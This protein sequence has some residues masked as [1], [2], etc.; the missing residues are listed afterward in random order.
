MLTD[1]VLS[2]LLA[3]TLPTRILC[4]TFTKAAAAE[5]ANR[6]ADRL[7]T[8][9]TVP[10]PA[11]AKMLGD[12]TGKAAARDQL[13]RA[14]RLFAQVVDAPGGLKIMTIH[15]F[16]QSLLRRFPLEAGLSPHFDVMDERS[17]AEVMEWARDEVLVRARHDVD[18]TL[19]RALAEVTGHA[20]EDAFLELMGD[21][22][23][24]RGRLA[25]ALK[26]LGGI[27]R[28]VQAVYHRLGLAPDATPKLVVEEACAEDAFEGA[29]LRASLEAL[30]QGSK[31]DKERGARIAAWLE[32][33][34]GRVRR[35]DD[36][37]SV[38]ITTE[39]TIRKNLATKAVRETSPHAEEVLRRE[40]E[41]IL[42]AIDRRKAATTAT[43]TIALLRLGAA[44]LDSY[45]RQKELAA[46]LDYDDLILR[47]R[48]LL[49]AHG[50]DWVLY[51]LDQGLDHILI[52]EAQ[53]TNPD[54]WAVIEALAEEFFVGE[55]A[56][57]ETRTVFAVG[58]AKQ[59][60][61]SF[62]RADPTAFERMRAHFAA[63]VRTAHGSWRSVAL[64]V[65][66]RSAP[67]V[68][69]AVDAV[70]ANSSASDGVVAEGSKMRHLAFRGG[71]AGL[72]ELWPVVSPRERKDFEPWSP[73]V[74]RESADSPSARLA[75]FL[76]R[77]IGRWIDDG[78]MLESKARPIRA[79]DVM[80]L[81]RR[82]GLFVDELVR[83]L[84]E[85]SVPVAGVDRMVLTDQLA[86]MDVMAMARFLLLPEDDLSLACVLKSPLVGLDED[87]LFALAYNRAPRTLWQSLGDRVE[88]DS[89]F[90]SAHAYLAGLLR[91][92]DFIPPYE[93]FAE[94]LGTRGR[95]DAKSGRERILARLGPEAEEP[96]DEFLAQALLYER[97]R[98]PS[99]EGFLHWIEAGQGEIKRDPE[100]SARNEV[101]IMTVHGAKGLQAPIVILPDTVQVPTQSPRL[102]WDEDGEDVFLWPPKRTHEESVAVRLRNTA[103][104]KRDQE[105]RRLLYV[106]MT[107]A[108][109]RLYVCG[110]RGSREAAAGAWHNLVAAGLEDVAESFAFDCR[111]EI[112]EGWSGEGLRL[113]S[114]QTALPEKDPR[115][116]VLSESAEPLP[117]WARRAPPPEPIPTRPLAPSR[118]SQDEPAVRSPLGSDEGWRFRRGTLVH[119]LL[120]ALPNLPP[121]KREP[122]AFNYLTRPAHGLS[123]AECRAIA[124]ETLAVLADPDFAPLFGPGSRAEAPIV[125]TVI[126]RAGSNVISGQIDR[127]LVTPEEILV[128]DYKT[129]RPPPIDIEDVASI[130]LNQMAAYRALLREVY[131]DR[132]VRCAL[133][134]TDGPRLMPL[135]DA[136]L[137]PYAP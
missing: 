106:A 64:E 87:Q 25:R 116:P 23:K 33:P 111:D 117:T 51:K 4:L 63:S 74:T 20:S 28:A 130:Y 76:A 85:A 80:V 93:L 99:L 137:D 107:R 94:I 65:S 66:F 95:P 43:A 90:A 50:A 75:G 6:V 34:I 54:Q 70:F 67:A 124:Q 31:A 72:V 44:L 18:E 128:V 109:D 112:A 57:T 9:A 61:Y 1:R 30:A 16:C 3:G 12:L 2:L 11:L 84:K 55:G 69:H 81:V 121:D 83:A 37:V 108:E 39:G 10:D 32:D 41:R 92:V 40:A 104:L 132:R 118:P 21:L 89:A 52:D 102:L 49:D 7:G 77:R 129:N 79:G 38:Y 42:E 35:F 103:N 68:L 22:A 133:L 48:E 5:M 46:L 8:W 13:E 100:A 110:W 98:V 105:Y 78:E 97:S 127:L 14:R 59:S 114:K 123:E 71:Q 126:G 101:R 91:R 58:D 96:L 113:V 62:Q 86:V 73:P 29:A 134:W 24:D 131:P 136:V 82:R 53:D 120:E 122:A 17:S 47:T 45:V 115:V 60:I 26:K 119:R 56:K 125:G 88:E 36:Y 15:A 27:D 135:P 19:A